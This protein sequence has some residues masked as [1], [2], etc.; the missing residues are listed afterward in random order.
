VQSMEMKSI[1]QRK[2]ISPRRLSLLKRR[3]K[4]FCLSRTSTRE[5]I[6]LKKLSK[7]SKTGPM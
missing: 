5:K 3:I 1:N 7:T 6:F 4:K 2:G